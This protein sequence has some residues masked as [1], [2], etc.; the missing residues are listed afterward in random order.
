MLSSWKTIWKKE[1]WDTGGIEWG[2]ASCC[3]INERVNW[4]ISLYADSCTYS[5][6]TSKKDL[7]YLYLCGV[8]KHY[9]Q[10]GA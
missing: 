9:I 1:M 3:S 6:N 10:N 7:K 4:N 2:V 5:E 8:K